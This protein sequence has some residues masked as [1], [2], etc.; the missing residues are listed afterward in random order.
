MTRTG[1]RFVCALAPEAAP[2]ISRFSMVAVGEARPFRVYRDPDHV[3]WLVLSGVGKS[4]A[5][6]AV[7]HLAAISG[8]GPAHTWINVGICGHQTGPVGR[9][10][11]ANKITD[12]GSGRCWYPSLIHRIGCSSDGLRTVDKP[13]QEYRETG[14]VDMEASG[15]YATAL[16]YTTQELVQVLKVVTDCPERPV[17]RFHA[18]EVSAQIASAMDVISELTDGCEALSKAEGR[19][20]ADPRAYGEILHTWHFS[21]S[22]KVQLR[23]LLIA[24]QALLDGVNPLVEL[25][26]ATTSR[27]VIHRLSEQVASAPVTWEKA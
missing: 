5:A 12:E 23:K 1:V 4:S 2:I 24:W 21:E 26:G 3:R 15:F 18:S 14:M 27:E 8:V 19:R 17:R 10:L 22:Q 16:R 7:A 20:L 13:D 6:A 11:R 25:E 9:V